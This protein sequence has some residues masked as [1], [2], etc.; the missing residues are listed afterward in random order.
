MKKILL[1]LL[2]VFYCCT[3][4]AQFPQDFENENVT[5]PDGFPPGWLVTDNGIG[6]TTNWTIQSAASVVIN[7][8]KS[9]YMNRQEIGQGNTSE[10]WLISPATVVPVNGQLRFFTKQTLAGDNGTI[11]QVRISTGAAQANLA[12]Y[13]V[14]QQWTENQLN[15][16]YNVAEE[17]LVD[18]PI[19]TIGSTVYIAFVRVYTQ[20]TTVQGG[21]RWIIDDINVKS[22]CLTPINLMV[23]NTGA[24]MATLGWSDLA[25]SSGYEVEFLP[26]NMQPTGVSTGISSTNSFVVTNLIPSTCYKYY[27]RSTC[28]NGESSAWAG[29]YNFCTLS[30]GSN[31][32]EPIVIS[33]LPYQTTDHTNNYSNTLIGPQVSS[34]IPVSVNYQS[35]NDVFY[36]YTATENTTLSFTLNSTQTRSSLF[37]YPSCAGTTGPCLAGTGNTTNTPR[38]LNYEVAAG[39]TYIIMISSATP[40]STIAYDLLIQNEACASKPTTL[41]TTNT[42]Q[43]TATLAWNAPSSSVL[44]YQ[45]A[46]QSPGSSV[47]IDSGQFTAA[48]PTF[49]VNNLTPGNTYQ[50]WVRSECSSGV[51]SSWVGPVTFTTQVCAPADQCSYIFR[52]TDTA[53]NGWNGARMDIRQNGVVVQTIGSTYSTGA[54]PVDVSVALCNNVPFDIFWS[55]AGTQPQQCVVSVVN[56]FGQTIATI[57]GSSVATNNIIYN[58]VSNCVT[59]LCTVAPTNVTVSNITFNG[60][61][62][63]WNAVATENLGFDIYIAPTGS[64]QPNGSTTPTY[65]GVNGSSGPFSYMIPT[66]NSLLAETFYDVYVRVQCEPNDSPWSAVQSFKTAIS[67]PQPTNQTVAA[68]GLNSATLGWT[69]AAS[70]TQW[71]VLILA[72]SNGVVPESTLAIPVVGA[73]DFYLTNLTG[74]TT[75]ITT[76]QSATMYYYYVRSICQ[77][78]NDKSQW[79]GP[80]MFNTNTCIAPAAIGIYQTTLTT[81][82]PIWIPA[83]LSHN[84]WEILVMPLPSANVP[85]TLPSANPVLENGA[86]ILPVSGNPSI[87]LSGLTS[88]TNYICYVRTVCNSTSKSE[89]LASELFSTLICSESQKCTYKFLLTNETNSNWYNGRIQVRQNGVVVA[90]LGT[91]GV[92]NSNGISVALCNNVPFDLYWSV[93][94][95]LPQEIGVTAI[96]AFGDIIYTKAPGEGTPLTVLFSDTTLGNCAPPTCPKSSDLIAVASQTSAQLSW[97]ET[98]SAN[99]WEVCVIPA[100][101]SPPVNGTPLN[102]GIEGFYL[103]S[104][105]SN[106]VVNGL[107]AATQYKYYVRPICSGTDIGNWNILTP[108]SFITTPLNDEC[109]DAISV[110]INPNQEYFVTVQG[111]TLGGTTSVE[112]STCPGNE[113]DDVWFSFVAT[114]NIHIVKLLNIIGTTTNLR[115]AIYSGENCATMTQMF[116][117]ATGNNTAVLANLMVGYTYKIRVYTNGNNPTQHATFNVGIGTPPP[118][119]TNDECVNA[120]PLTVNYLSECLYVTPGNLIGATASIGLPAACTGSEDDDVWFSFIATSNTNIINLLNIEGTTS[121]LNHA[122]FSGTCENLTQFYC[123]PANTLSSTDF[124]FV[125]GQTYYVRI[126]SNG[127]SSEVV[128]FDVCVKPIS[129]CSTAA[130]FCSSS[131]GAPYV[132]PNT[133]GVPNSTQIAC[134]ASVPNPTYYTINVNQSGPL[135]FTI[136]QNSNISPTGELLGTNLDVDFVAWG[137]FA[138]PESCDEIVFADCPSCPNNTTN[139]NF[140]PL[141]NIVDCSYDASSTETVS[142]PNA[143]A[144][145]YYIILIT[146]FNGSAG[147]ISMFQNNYDEPNA[148]QTSC[149]DIIQLVAFVD[150]NSNGI[151]EESET[152]FT[153][154][155]FTFQKNNVGNTY[156]ISNPLGVQNIFDQNTANTYDFNYEIN[157]EYEAYYAE[158]PT[159]FNDLSIQYGSG[160]QSLFF[161]I[162]ITQTYSDVDVVIIPTGVPRPGFT[163]TQKIVYRNLGVIPTSGTLNYSKGNANITITNNSITP[164]TT[165][166]N[167]FTLDYVDLAPGETRYINLTMTV[168]SIP[169]VNLGDLATCSTSITSVENDINVVNNTF[170]IAQA[171]VASYDPNDKNEAR[172]TA[173]DINQFSQDDYLFYTIRFQNTGT[174]SAETVRIEDLL[175]S[176][177]DFASIRMISASHHYSMERINNKLVWTFNNINLPGA[178]QSEVFSQGYVTFKIKLNPGFAV[179]DVIDNTA[180]IYFDTN[181]AIITNTFQSTFMESLGV[182]GFTSTNILLYPNPTNSM[183][184]INLQNT[185]ESLKNIIVYDMIGKTI[186]TISGNTTQQASVSVGDLAKGVYMI[187]ITT[188]KNLKQVRK[189]I[190]N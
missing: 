56:S 46:V 62:I 159:N 188:D 30:I 166:S 144:G 117:S 181:P 102:T 133:I 177:F 153:Y 28:S 162:T 81:A 70:A 36:S 33:N 17:K 15:Q 52:M 27:V 189:F 3:G 136:F 53:N 178:F 11:Y 47:P 148:G 110:P 125:V 130:P 67:C 124:N 88:A 157:S 150:A 111:S 61:T 174:A 63:N 64:P 10:D 25:G 14:L 83:L 176:E 169:I 66:P 141:G 127:S 51:F 19:S 13:T 97:T 75:T 179:G 96:N 41:A 87:V 149:G 80:F 43:T 59:P 85:A 55:I 82:N 69:E 138:S 92:N 135:N 16:V 35:G 146:N 165:T 31:C 74:I 129:T 12:S 89:W 134:L 147:F 26:S 126:W 187:E 173:I 107:T 131:A 50:F 57:N 48:T 137:P 140:Y 7:G 77:S 34:C 103:A 9:A 5:V 109:N 116:C 115:F 190:V 76:L 114:N 49:S 79:T 39:S 60:G 18:L 122:V 113:N 108:E 99:Q 119:G 139:P 158:T 71:D 142:I 171:V 73:N 123:A 145:E 161:P 1:L 170:V 91:G 101:G 164:T 4:F 21:D 24:T 20:P 68:I 180:E 38:I 94:G 186:K 132:F 151:K 72:G 44:G 86:Y 8:T 128:T 32:T 29:P 104:T 172:G 175:A 6:T 37:I 143:Q 84:A 152:N 93:A 2:I 100:G 168:P 167:G 118:P 154:G 184:H 42:T 183:L 90:T 155:S 163:Y 65:S 185:N 40:V 45:I 106:F 78:E 182:K 160:V 95:E 105:N 98:G 112:S 54:G 121:N 120:I 22:K 156:H 23:L 58:G